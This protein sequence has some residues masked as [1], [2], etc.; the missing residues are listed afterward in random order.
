LAKIRNFIKFGGDLIWQMIDFI[1][2]W[3]GFN[4]ADRHYFYFGGDLFEIRQ[5]STRQNK[6]T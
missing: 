6:Y 4:L 3:W 2:F 1:K 5:I